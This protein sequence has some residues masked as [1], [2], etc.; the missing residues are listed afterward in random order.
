MKMR[1]NCFLLVLIGY[2]IESSQSFQPASFL[3]KDV[4]GDRRKSITLAANEREDLIPETSFGAEVVPE[5][6][7]PV[8][9][10]LDMRSS[11]LFDWA[12]NEAGSKG[13]SEVV[14]N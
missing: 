11:P 10:Y 8:N 14:I 12:S 3:C 5:G 9:E 7:R 13:V 1:L 4:K 6:Q 2:A